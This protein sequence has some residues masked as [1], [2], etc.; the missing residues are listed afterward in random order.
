MRF[1]NKLYKLVKKNNSK[2]CVGLDPIKFPFFKFN[3]AII[4]Q[5]ADLVCAYK[6][7]I[8][9]YE[10]QGINGFKELK[11][12]VVY[13]QKKYPEIPI[14]LDAKRG[15]IDTANLGYL[16]MAFEFFKV[17]ALTLHPYL[18]KQSLKPFLKLKN[19]FFFI[20]CR[21]SNFG[22]GEFQDLKINKKPLY[23]I[24]A[25]N[26][27]QDWNKYNNCGL[28]AGATYP[29][30]I[31]EIRKID[32]KILLLIPGIGAQGGNLLET[33]KAAK[34]NF[35]INLSRAIIYSN[36][37]RKEVKKINKIIWSANKT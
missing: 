23:Q 26:V 37:P 31:S 35:I 34:N 33:L 8:A 30:E 1:I 18:G 32:K 29:R 7:N 24:I 27:S 2:L 11:K 36:N 16:K 3:K 10:A 20:L 6:P 13:I 12:T 22:S 14:I 4:D 15:D 9:F 21:T 28:V 5:T 25:S 17:D 19:K